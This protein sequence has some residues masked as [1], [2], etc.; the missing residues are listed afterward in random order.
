LYSAEAAVS[1]IIL[2]V[3]GCFFAS[4][5]K[6]SKIMMTLFP[7]EPVY[8]NGFQYVDDFISEEEEKALVQQTAQLTLHTFRF[9]GYKAKR[10]VASFGYDWSFEKQTLSKGS[11]IPETFHWLIERVAASLSL[12]PSD[13]AE[14]LVT[15]YPVGSVI[16][17][18]RDAPPFALI[19]GISLNEDCVFKLRPY[20]KEKQSKKSIVSL[21]V[22]RRSLYVMQGEARE[23][24]QHSIEAVK[25]VRYS[26]TLRTLKSGT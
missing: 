19:A 3:D 9:Q 8:P 2:L 25:K 4:L 7:V 24:W 17:W 16:N 18:H 12:S 5:Q 23:A 15:K 6:M 20:E 26:I 11:D 10:K 21:P 1:Q 14:L 22:K 13:F